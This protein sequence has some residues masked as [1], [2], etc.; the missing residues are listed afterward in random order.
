MVDNGSPNACTRSIILFD[1]NVVGRHINLIFK[2]EGGLRLRFI[3]DQL[4]LLCYCGDQR[5]GAYV[6]F[7]Y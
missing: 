5:S 6:R 7:I 1:I 3:T 2:C 4:E